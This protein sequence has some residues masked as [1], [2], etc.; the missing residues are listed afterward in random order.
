[1][2]R[3]CTAA[4]LKRRHAQLLGLGG[5]GKRRFADERLRLSLSG[6]DSGIGSGP[7]W[8]D[9]ADRNNSAACMVYTVDPGFNGGIL[10]TGSRE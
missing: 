2:R 3:R 7:L 10:S 1:M 8:S 9:R 4:Q 5:K 6:T